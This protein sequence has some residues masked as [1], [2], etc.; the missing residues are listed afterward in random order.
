[1]SMRKSRVDTCPWMCLTCSWS[2]RQKSQSVMWCICWFT[3]HWL[4]KFNSHWESNSSLK[5]GSHWHPT[6]LNFRSFKVNMKPFFLFILCYYILITIFFGGGEYCAII[7]FDFHFHS[8]TAYTTM[9]KKC[10]LRILSIG[11]ID[12]SNEC[13]GCRCTFGRLRSSGM[14]L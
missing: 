7:N 5:W 9:R 1:M 6:A 12:E 14:Q 10:M 11:Y 4:T 2:F 3:P 13:E 8:A